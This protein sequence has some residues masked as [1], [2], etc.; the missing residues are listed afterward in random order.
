MAQVKAME[1]K[2]KISIDKTELHPLVKLISRFADFLRL[3]VCIVL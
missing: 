2:C 1:Q 3:P